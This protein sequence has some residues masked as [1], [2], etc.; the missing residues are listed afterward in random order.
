VDTEGLRKGY[1]EKI[2]SETGLGYQTVL[3]EIISK[4]LR[5]A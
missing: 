2:A 3:K 4:G 5:N 1:T